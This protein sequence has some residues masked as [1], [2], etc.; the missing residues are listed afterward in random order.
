MLLNLDFSWLMIAVAVVAM[1][2]YI[3]GL[4]LDGVMG[5]DGFGALG[6]A[7][8][9][10]AGFFLG[11]LAANAYGITLRDLSLAVGAGL[12]GALLCL[13]LL[14]GCKAGLNRL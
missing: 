6:N 13:G 9:V 11:I 4:A 7:V 8:I 1:L 10:T 3:F 2:S 14:A 12:F 5:S